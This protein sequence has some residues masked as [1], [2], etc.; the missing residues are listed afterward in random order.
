MQ[1]Q[2]GVVEPVAAHRNTSHKGLEDW[3]LDKELMESLAGMVTCEINF[4]QEAFATGEK[5]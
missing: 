2:V 4:T 1:I 5:E 3:I